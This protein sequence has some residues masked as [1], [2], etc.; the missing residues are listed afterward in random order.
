MPRRPHAVDE[1]SAGGREPGEEA[2]T[3]VVGGFATWCGPGAVPSPR[4]RGR[5]GTRRS[6]GGVEPTGETGGVLRLDQPIGE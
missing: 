3:P 1:T 4:G 6:E 2:G 5:D